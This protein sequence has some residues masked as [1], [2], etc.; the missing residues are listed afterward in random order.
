MNNETQ[1]ESIFDAE[2]A[3]I[4][5]WKKSEGKP[6]MFYKHSD[7][8]KWYE[9]NLE[10]SAETALLYKTAPQRSQLWFDARKNRITL[11]TAGYHLGY[12]KYNSPAQQNVDVVWK[13]DKPTNTAMY[14]GTVFEDLGVHYSTK[15]ASE[16]LFPMQLVKQE[17]PGLIINS[18]VPWFG[19]SVDS[20]M[21]YK[22]GD[23]KVSVAIEQKCP[24]NKSFYWCVNA[25]HVLQAVGNAILTGADWAMYSQYC[26]SQSRHFWYKPDVEWFSERLAELRNI[27]FTTV[28]PALYLKSM[29]CLQEGSLIPHI[30]ITL[31]TKD[32][33]KLDE[34]TSEDE[35][36]VQT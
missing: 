33:P 15:H 19:G 3:W 2:A 10:I 22:L 25:V 28:L 29:G 16:R 14:H 7:L 34:T 17:T 23:Q 31:P 6:N 18:K 35:D 26:T 4:E 20:Y 30:K 5:V 8:V 11:S 9:K 21:E 32:I 36:D 12:S 27:Y 24:F 13:K 1:Y